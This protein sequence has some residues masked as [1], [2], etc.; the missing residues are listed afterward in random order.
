M[1]SKNKH[2]SRVE[3][4]STNEE[5][6]PSETQQLS[7]FGAELIGP[8]RETSGEFGTDFVILRPLQIFHARASFNNAQR[9]RVAA[10]LVC[11]FPTDTALSPHSI[12]YILM[13][14]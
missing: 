4:S 5:R 6:P 13:V 3:T 12:Y 8:D 10:T 9:L 11:L 14:I 7:A 1:L 2:P